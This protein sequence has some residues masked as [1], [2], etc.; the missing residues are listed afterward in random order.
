VPDKKTG[1]RINYYYAPKF[2]INIDAEGRLQPLILMITRR[3]RNMEGAFKA[4]EE[5]NRIIGTKS[6]GDEIVFHLYEG[7]TWCNDINYTNIIS[8]HYFFRTKVL[9]A[10]VLVESKE[11]RAAFLDFVKEELAASILG[12]DKTPLTDL[13]RVDTSLKKFGT[14][15]GGRL[16]FAPLSWNT[17]I[18]ITQYQGMD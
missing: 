10:T 6:A 18:K 4:I 2:F 11:R 15:D 3:Y 16:L 1:Y 7:K 12:P 17:C 9:P 14:W 8:G 13:P 5:D